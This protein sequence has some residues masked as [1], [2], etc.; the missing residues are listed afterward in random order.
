[1]ASDPESPIDE[2]PICAGCTDIGHVADNC[3]T[4]NL[5]HGLQT[6]ASQ[7]S[8]YILGILGV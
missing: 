3:P 8:T 4:L 6:M 5:L 1:M 7:L 2:Y